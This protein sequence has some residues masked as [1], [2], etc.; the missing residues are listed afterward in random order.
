MQELTVIQRYFR[1]T[2]RN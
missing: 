2:S 1:W